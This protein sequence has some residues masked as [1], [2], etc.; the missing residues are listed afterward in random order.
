[1]TREGQSLVG[2]SLTPSGEVPGIVL[3]KVWL[4]KSLLEFERDLRFFQIV[5]PTLPL[6]F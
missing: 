4:F 6:F 3:Y 1:M 2:L 5:S